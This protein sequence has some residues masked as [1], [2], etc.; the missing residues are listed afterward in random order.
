M[1]EADGD[2]KS[3]RNEIHKMRPTNDIKK[4]LK[5]LVFYPKS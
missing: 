1:Q 2:M 3:V 4:Q 5:I